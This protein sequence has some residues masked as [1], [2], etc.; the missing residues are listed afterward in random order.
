VRLFST[1]LV[2]H[3]EC[4]HECELS[5]TLLQVACRPCMHAQRL[6]LVPSRLSRASGVNQRPITLRST[7]RA[8]RVRT[9]QT[10]SNELTEHHVAGAIQHAVCTF[11]CSIPCERLCLPNH[12][13]CCLNDAGRDDEVHHS[14]HCAGRN[15][16][17]C[18]ESWR[19]C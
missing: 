13:I 8:V 1:I 3:C 15:S 10:S 2:A 16:W 17:Q 11:S 14:G 4:P 19:P 5:V 6:Q 12:F 9:G 7:A 18:S